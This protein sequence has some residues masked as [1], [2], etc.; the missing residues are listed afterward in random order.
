V[1]GRS[2]RFQNAAAPEPFP[3]LSK[4][5]DLRARENLSRPFFVRNRTDNRKD[6]SY[7][8]NRAGLPCPA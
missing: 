6:F 2:A 7:N 8:Q 3:A 4:R 5:Y 1:P